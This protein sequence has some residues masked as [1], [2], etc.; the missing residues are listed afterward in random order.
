[1][2]V[3]TPSEGTTIFN[4]LKEKWEDIQ[5]AYERIRAAFPKEPSPEEEDLCTKRNNIFTRVAEDYDNALF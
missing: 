3:T 2:T 1:M 5:R 4:Y